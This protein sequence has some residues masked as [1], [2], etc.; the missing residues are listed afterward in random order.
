[1]D[2][3]ALAQAELKADLLRELALAL[4]LPLAADS[5]KN[6]DDLT[7]IHVC[8]ALS[9]GMDSSVLLHLLSILQSRYRTKTFNLSA[10]HIN[11]QLS[12]NADS[13]QD[14][15]ADKCQH[16]NIEFA[17]QVV[18]VDRKPRQSLEAIARKK[19]YQALSDTFRLMHK[20][21]LGVEQAN[22]KMCI[23]LGQHKDDQAET[24]LLQVKRG[25]GV[26]G[27][28]SMASHFERHNTQ[29][30]R[31]LLKFTREQLFSFAKHEK[32][33]WIEDESNDD[34]SFDRNYLRQNVMPLMTQK[35]PQF[36]TTLSRSARLCAEADTVI[37]EYMAALVP[38][39][40]DAQNRIN[41][42]SLTALSL[43]TQRSFLRFCLSSYL[44]VTPS[45]KQI[46]EILGLCLQTT[47]ASAHIRIVNYAVERFQEQLVISE[48]T[49][50]STNKENLSQD[51][52]DELRTLIFDQTGLFE[53]SDKITLKQVFV[54]AQDKANVYSLPSDDL[55]WSFA[56][57]NLKFKPYENRPTK[58]LKKWYQEWGISPIQRQK[59]IVIS[60]QS[61]AYMLIIEDEVKCSKLAIEQANYVK[62][63]F[64]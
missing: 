11:H 3:S 18:C 62:V 33:V 42:A 35:W 53:I 1:M 8:V 58:A 39:I 22:Q 55:K 54:K 12:Q 41:I 59:V 27:L 43:P 32:L 20:N 47:K 64:S 13:W 40:C 25:A 51:K 19:R 56:A 5:D 48:I 63:I 10:I 23:A 26:K 49:H 38:T 30:V 60:S 17:S 24:F 45:L 44:K 34:E 50:P 2:A 37:D 57:S 7:H 16:Y 46:E 61:Q 36:T 52:H 9:G 29:F 14:F 31:P 21:S 15:C 28:A 6:K 4:V